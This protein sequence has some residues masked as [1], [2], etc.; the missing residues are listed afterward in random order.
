MPG[1]TR[2]R[3]AFPLETLDRWERFMLAGV[4]AGFLHR[5]LEDGTLT[6]RTAFQPTGQQRAQNPSLPER[7]L[8]QCRVG[9][10]DD[11]ATWRWLDYEDSQTSQRV[12]V[13]RR[14]AG[15]DEDVVPSYAEPLLAAPVARRGEPVEFLRFEESSPLHGPR[16]VV[17]ARLRPVAD[18]PPAGVGLE[19]ATMTR[20]E[21][22]S[23]G[24]VLC[25]HVLADDRMLASDW[26][27]GAVTVPVEGR[28]DAL[29][30]LAQDLATF[31]D[32]PR[33]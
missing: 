8:S 19:A 10:T 14:R 9:L 31:A 15:I 29:A 3:P 21:T 4:H 25:A 1:Q 22:V 23:E 12:H 16:R 2:R 26:G 17:P 27:A 6:V 11:G 24:Q 18:T 7:F 30:G 5:H 28:R 33:G 13:D 32:L 20:V